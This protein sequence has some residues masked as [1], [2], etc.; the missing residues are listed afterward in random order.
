GSRHGLLAFSE[1][2][3]DYYQIPVADRQA[4]LA[5]ERAYAEARE[6]GQNGRG[7]RRNRPA[8][9]AEKAAPAD[10]VTTSDDIPGMT[11]VDL[12][13]EAE[14]AEAAAAP[15]EIEP[16]SEPAAEPRAEDSAGEREEPYVAADHA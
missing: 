15:A 8:A 16:R 12:R 4:L 1:I 5:E 13:E 10:A 14:A 7:R 11:V 2:H 6:A 3:P 9:K